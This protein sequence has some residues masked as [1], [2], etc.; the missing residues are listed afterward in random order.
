MN[1]IEPQMA[2]PDTPQYMLKM[3][4]NE[5]RERKEETANMS[6]KVEYE[7]K[8]RDLE[9]RSQ[10]GL[11]KLK[12][13]MKHVFNLDLQNLKLTYEHQLKQL[14]ISI[15]KQEEENELLRNELV[16]KDSE[17]SLIKER[18]RHF[19]N[20]RKVRLEHAEFLC[21]VSPRC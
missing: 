1:R 2:G 14:K 4:L 19:E 12:S 21:R 9:L 8:M 5:L 18:I 17:V 7:Q 11:A 15:K 3:V 20:E 13:Q 6:L 16:K 10:D